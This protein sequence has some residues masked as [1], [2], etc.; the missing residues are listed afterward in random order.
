MTGLTT[1]TPIGAVALEP[2]D[3]ARHLDLLHAWV[4]HPRSAF[5]Q[6]QGATV[7]DVRTEYAAIE[8]DPHHAA[9]IGTVDGVPAFLVEHY[10]PAHSD[11]AGHLV[12]AD[13][14]VGMHV[15]VAPPADDAAPVRGY[16]DAVFAAVMADL[17]TDPDVTRVV[18]EPDVRNDAIRAKNVAAGFVE[19]HPIELP[20]KTAMLSTCSREAFAASRLGGAHVVR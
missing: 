10:D 20:S 17:F 1:S 3:L 8:A 4:T 19:L 15:L 16:T 14:Y 7:D 9:L 18:V 6:M 12:N 11:L 13:G 2:L 5:W